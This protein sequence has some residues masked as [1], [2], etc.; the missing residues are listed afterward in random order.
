M[1]V[2]STEKNVLTKGIEVGDYIGVTTEE[3]YSVGVVSKIREETFELHGY[4]LSGTYDAHSQLNPRL[5]D[6]SFY[7]GE[8]LKRDVPL[9]PLHSYLAED[10]KHMQWT[11]DQE[12]KSRQKG[13]TEDQLIGVL[14]RENYRFF[15]AGIF[16]KDLFLSIASDLY[17]FNQD[18]ELW[19]EREDEYVYLCNECNEMY[20]DGLAQCEQA[21]CTGSIRKVQKGDMGM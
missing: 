15:D 14:E 7:F 18:E 1:T 8:V 9:H 19:Y 2:K 10:F 16:N 13:L 6:M 5:H 17:E 21:D 12:N 11:A 3:G 4:L 20:E